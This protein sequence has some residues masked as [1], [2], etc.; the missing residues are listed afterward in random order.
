MSELNYHTQ[1][2]DAI[3]GKKIILEAGYIKMYGKKVRGSHRHRA[4][5]AEGRQDAVAWVDIE[6][7]PTGQF[8]LSG[9][10]T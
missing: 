5:R 10:G 8:K 2:N 3:K 1:L 6:I 4:Q 9:S 7:Y